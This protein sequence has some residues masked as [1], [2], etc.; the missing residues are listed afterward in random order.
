MGSKVPDLPLLTMKSWIWIRFTFNRTLRG[1]KFEFAYYLV[2]QITKVTITAT[3]VKK[4]EKVA[5]T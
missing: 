4:T 5:V 3:L 1:S 2:P